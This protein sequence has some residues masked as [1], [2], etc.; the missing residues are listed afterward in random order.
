MSSL[1]PTMHD[2]SVASGSVLDQAVAYDIAKENQLM[3]FLP[4][5]PV[6]GLL[7]PTEVLT[8]IPTLLPVSNLN[9]GYDASKG[10]STPKD[11]KLATW[12]DKSFV[13]VMYKTLGNGFTL[14]DEIK[15][16]RII[17][18]TA[19]SYAYSEALFNGDQS[20]DTKSFNGLKKETN[21]LSEIVINAGGTGSALTS[22]YFIRLDEFGLMGLYNQNIGVTP[23][24]MDLGIQ[25]VIDPIT[26]K[27]FAARQT[28]HAMVNGAYINKAGIGRLANIDSGSLPTLNLLN[29]IDAMMKWRPDIIIT[30]RKGYQ[31]LNNLSNANLQTFVTDDKLKTG[32]KTYDGIPI[33]KTDFI[34]QTETQVV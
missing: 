6:D 24:M 19:L 3:A 15:R 21:A 14:E 12:R 1:F 32:V 33:L 28:E 4:M 29:E 5:R 10:E 9:Q 34:T 23:E 22:I 16:Q 26:G 11:F 20:V 13:D 2:H 17:K 18:N 8:T 7:L 30:G 31:L 27:T 25:N